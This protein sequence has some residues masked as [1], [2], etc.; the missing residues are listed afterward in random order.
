M[1]ITRRREPS[2]GNLREQIDR[3]FEEFLGDFPSLSAWQPFRMHTFPA[4]N[5]WEGDDNMYVEAELPGVS[6][7]DVE[8]SVAGS[9][10]TIKGQRPRPEPE[11]GIGLRR[12]ERRFGPF[13]RVVRLPVAVD[14][15]RIEA[16]LRDGLLFVTLPKAATSRPRRVKVQAVST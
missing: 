10:L 7:E 13:N 3:L 5:V 2:L 8:L 11:A 14:N 1:N 4:V 12:S 6:G 15:G 16:T 9:E